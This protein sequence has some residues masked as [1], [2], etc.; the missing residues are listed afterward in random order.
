MTG[1]GER[2]LTRQSDLARLILLARSDDG[3]RGHRAWSPGSASASK[4]RK[5]GVHR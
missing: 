1:G 4:R 3:T 5:G 2:E